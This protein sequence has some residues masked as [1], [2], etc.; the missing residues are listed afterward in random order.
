M[1]QIVCDIPQE[2]WVDP[3]RGIILEFEGVRLYDC[4]GYYS[5]V[6][7]ELGIHQEFECYTSAEKRF[8]VLVNHQVE[9]LDFADHAD[10]L[11]EALLSEGWELV[12]KY[13]E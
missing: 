6:C 7:Q 2:D 13:E 12:S 3:T 10:E 11:A 8:K 1:F 5:V 4:L 9:V